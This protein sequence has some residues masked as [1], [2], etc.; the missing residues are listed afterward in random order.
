MD[1]Q[2]LIGV[3]VVHVHGDI[4]VHAADGVHQGLKALQ[5]HQ[6]R[7]IHRDAQ[8]F[9]HHVGQQLH[10]AGVVS[11]VDLVVL[12][13]EIG[14]GVPGDAD[15]GYVVVGGIQRHED[16][17][18]ASA[19]AVIHAGD[20]DGVKV[21]FTDIVGRDGGG[22]RRLCLG[23]ILCLLSGARF[24]LGLLRG[25]KHAVGTGVQRGE[26]KD[27][28]QKGA[29][30]IAALVAAVGSGHLKQCSL[31]ARRGRG[32]DLHNTAP[33]I[34]PLRGKH[35]RENSDGFSVSQ[36]EIRKIAVRAAIFPFAVHVS[37]VRSV[38]AAL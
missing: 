11:G 3:V 7:V 16:V 17:G 9:R 29:P 6:H 33:I 31:A 5:I 20:Q 24:L 38:A 36:S 34:K 10:A 35:K 18:V 2:A 32:K 37:P 12:A 22:D 19:V 14:L 25:T 26:K 30:P 27:Q 23:I 13:V 21:L 15:A 28:Q 8:L 1:G 4:E